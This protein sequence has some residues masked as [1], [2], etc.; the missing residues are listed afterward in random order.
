[1]LVTCRSFTGIDKPRISSEKGRK[2]V[3]AGTIPYR[4]NGGMV[5]LVGAMEFLQRTQCTS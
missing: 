5:N 4:A 3:N 1:M 2:G